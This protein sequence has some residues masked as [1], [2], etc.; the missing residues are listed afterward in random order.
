MTAGT[1]AASTAVSKVAPMVETSVVALA[2]QRA[3]MRV[4]EW[5]YR[6]V[7]KTVDA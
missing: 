7:V 4:D 1:T 3:A 6:T 5:D 2:G